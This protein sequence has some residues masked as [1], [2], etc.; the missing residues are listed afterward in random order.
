MLIKEICSEE[1]VICLK[2][3]RREI[4]DPE[5]KQRIYDSGFD[6]CHSTSLTSFQ[7]GIIGTDTGRERSPRDPNLC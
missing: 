1:L 7:H 6:D 3:Q 4:D 2:S 5:S